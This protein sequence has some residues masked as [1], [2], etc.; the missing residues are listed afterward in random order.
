MSRASAKDVITAA[1][2]GDASL[3]EKLGAFCRVATSRA[4]EKDLVSI[5]KALRDTQRFEMA[6]KPQRLLVEVTS[7]RPGDEAHRTLIWL[8][9][10]VGTKTGD[11]AAARVEFVRFQGEV[12]LNRKANLQPALDRLRKEFPGLQA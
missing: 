2:R 4:Y 8:L 10:K 5:V 12:A 6:I 9:A 1:Q 11:M 7:A 3:R